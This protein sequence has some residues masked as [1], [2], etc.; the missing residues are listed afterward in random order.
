MKR[1]TLSALAAATVFLSALVFSG[2]T[3][4]IQWMPLAALV[5]V[6][7]V[8]LNSLLAS[9][10]SELAAKLV[11]ILAG[12][13]IVAATLAAGL[14]ERLGDTYSLIMQSVPPMPADP[15]FRLFL[16]LLV[17]AMYLIADSALALGSVWLG[18]LALWVPYLIIAFAVV[19]PPGA[20][21]FL[22]PVVAVVLW[23]FGTTMA[24]Y[25]ERG[26][27]QAGPILLLVVALAAGSCALTAVAQSFINT[28]R[29]KSDDQLTDPSLN[30]RRDLKQGEKREMLRYRHAGDMGEGLYLRQAVLQELDEEGFYPAVVGRD[31]AGGVIGEDPPSMGSLATTEHVDVVISL[32]AVHTWLPLVWEPMTTSALP[33]GQVDEENRTVF[34]RENAPHDLTYGVRSYYQQPNTLSKQVQV[35]YQDSSSPYLQVPDAY[36]N[37]L[38]YLAQEEFSR[39]ADSPEELVRALLGYFKDFKYEIVNTEGSSVETIADFAL[40]DKT[41]YC[42]QF[43]G[44]FAILARMM[45][46]PSRVVLGYAPGYL[47]GDSWVVTNYQ[48]H[49]WVELGLNGAWVPFDPTPA[50]GLAQGVERAQQENTVSPTPTSAETEEPTL[51]PESQSATPTPSVAPQG[52]GGG[53]DSGQLP[54]ALGV[55]GLVVVLVIVGPTIWRRAKRAL[56]ISS[57]DPEKI[58]AEVRDLTRDLGGEWVSGTPRQQAE[59]AA[60]AFEAADR[61]DIWTLAVAVE[62]GRFAKGHP[63]VSGSAKLVKALGKPPLSWWPRSMRFPT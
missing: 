11:L 26:R 32:K 50:S 38:G 52:A 60:P 24:R 30:L 41:G 36:W 47:D 51:A 62:R 35:N 4:D 16:V 27:S 54:W 45:G 22:F 49:A 56:R 43:A 20:E 13:L 42:E 46:I 55:V 23:L 19:N 18:S 7:S 17:W 31:F 9:K 10:F 5:L 8:G 48:A 15:G 57:D 33:L 37:V 21:C 14:A 44:T 2:I 25:P 61:S 40:R 39:Y 59:A 34:F 63:K 1:A 12:L 29:N 53:G 6:I 3:E 28:S 58:W